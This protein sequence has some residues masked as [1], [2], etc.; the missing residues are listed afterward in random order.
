[1]GVG[2]GC[3]WISSRTR[4]SS[5]F[6]FL[7]LFLFLVLVLAADFDFAESP[8]NPPRFFTRDLS[9]AIDLDVS[10]IIA[11]FLLRTVGIG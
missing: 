8:W 7:F 5:L 1:M 6:L 10:T 11:F 4:V 9:L 3:R 2:S